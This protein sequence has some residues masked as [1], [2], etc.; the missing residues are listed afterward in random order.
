M[1]GH[2]V[3]VP[4]ASEEDL[5]RVWRSRINGIKD[6]QGRSVG[7]AE[8]VIG[9]IVR[10]WGH[11]AHDISRVLAALQAHL[12]PSVCALAKD[13]VRAFVMSWLQTHSSLLRCR[14][15]RNDDFLSLAEDADE[16]QD[17]QD[18]SEHGS[19]AVDLV[20]DASWPHVQLLTL[21][22]SSATSAL[23]VSDIL[24][25][26]NGNLLF[27]YAIAYTLQGSD[28][29]LTLRMMSPEDGAVCEPLVR[30]DEVHDFMGSSK[31]LVRSGHLSSLGLCFDVRRP[32]QRVAMK[33]ITEALL[34]R[35]NKP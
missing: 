16:G 35:P 23:P 8:E 26:P 9:S 33:H 31:C 13:D 6:N 18:G 1:R 22:A 12:V 4:H 5:C 29:L 24:E 25:Q 3:Y 7:S 15:R 11:E 27:T 20:K 10:T 14:G 32:L 28:S 30:S 17:D 21:I 2:A 19:G 34:V